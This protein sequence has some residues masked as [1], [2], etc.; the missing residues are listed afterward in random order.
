MRDHILPSLAHPQGLSTPVFGAQ[1]R[2][3]TVE[4]RVP[5]SL[6]GTRMCWNCLYNFTWELRIYE[7][8][9]LE[10]GSVV[11]MIFSDGLITSKKL[12]RII[13]EFYCCIWVILQAFSCEVTCAEAGWFLFHLDLRTATSTPTI[14]D[15]AGPFLRTEIRI[16]SLAL[17]YVAKSW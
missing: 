13:V 8:S 2:D 11:F 12:R 9:F 17:F 15:K 5:K 3:V 10:R 7:H 4:D 16:V 14:Q 1:F 6:R